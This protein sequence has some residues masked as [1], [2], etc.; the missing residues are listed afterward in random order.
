M[1]NAQ[2]RDVVRDVAE[3]R[4]DASS[5]IACLPIEPQ[6]WGFCVACAPQEPWAAHAARRDDG[7]VHRRQ[8]RNHYRATAGHASVDPFPM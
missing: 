2:P 4:A 6:G 7:G 5:R 1:L 8:P 3:C